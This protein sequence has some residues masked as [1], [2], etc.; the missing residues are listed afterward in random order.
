MAQ[1][2]DEGH[3]HT[4]RLK[5]CC[6]ST[7]Q[8]SFKVFWQ[9]QCIESSLGINDADQSDRQANSI[10]EIPILNWR[11]AIKKVLTKFSLTDASKDGFENSLILIGRQIEQEKLLSFLQDTIAGKV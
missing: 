4:G 11:D 3:S 2:F 10:Q 1:G 5:M 9:Q 6:E 7:R 8:I